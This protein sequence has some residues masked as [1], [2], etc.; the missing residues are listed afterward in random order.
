MSATE[1]SQGIRTL[2]DR[3]V[4]VHLSTLRGSGAPRSWV[5]WAGREED[6]I[7]ICTDEANGKAKDMRRD[8]RVGLS[9]LDPANPYHVGLIE[10]RVREVRPDPDCHYMDALAIKYTGA[11]F[12]HHARDRVCFVI[13]AMTVR[14]RT[15][16]F[17]HDPSRG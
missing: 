16:G 7:L 12:P 14:E 8:P 1:L 6:W 2:L 13:E 10:G 17:T 11:P 15:L 5:V 9:F 4:F 3:P